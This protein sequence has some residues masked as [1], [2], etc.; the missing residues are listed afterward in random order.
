MKLISRYILRFHIG[1]FIFGTTLVMFLFLFQF[2]L[3]SLDD[4]VGKGLSNWVII[5]LIALNLSWM[6]V[7]AVPMG[8]LFS[9]VMA[10][11]NLS[12]T[13]EVTII[14]AS[15]GSLIRM[16]KPVVI[17]G[18]FLTLILFWF[19]DAILPEANHR[20]KVLWM[21][22]KRKKPTFTLESGQFSQELEG[23]TLIARNVDSLS[24]KLYGVTIYDNRVMDKNNVISADSG[25]V[26]F[27]SDMQK[28]VI[29]LFSGEIHQIVPYQTKDYRKI[30]FGKYIIFID[31][32]GYN[33]TRTDDDL[34]S[35]GDREMHISD[36]QK[37]VD[38][39]NK[40]E[41]KYKNEFFKIIKKHY[42]FLVGLSDDTVNN[43]YPTI[44]YENQTYE[45]V[46]SNVQRN[47]SFLK[48]NLSTH[49]LRFEDYSRK[50]GQYEVEIQKKYSIPFACLIFILVGSPLG[51]MTKGGNF[52]ISAAI[53]IAFY[54]FYWACLIAGEKLADRGI[55]SPFLSMWMGN[56][57]ILIMGTILVI[58]TNNE[59]FSLPTIFKKF[60][61]NT[62]L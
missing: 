36:M 4:L 57:S 52:G 54:I 59:S 7:L 3:K 49:L 12:S 46:L 27:T 32:R 8:V 40:N 18:I 38:E 42:N 29:K 62:N 2:L 26:N 15:G 20:A 47:L 41:Q 44:Y 13:H 25:T 23:Y 16:I 43:S 14:K 45:K 61:H 60:R 39:A 34:I 50:A 58:K 53:S 19:N 22:I 51:I 37:I 5:Q 21:D 30:D 17:S 28:L 6:L 55:L 48:N 33:L 35:R 1:P 10:F 56:L 24:G 11:G 31:A 9:T